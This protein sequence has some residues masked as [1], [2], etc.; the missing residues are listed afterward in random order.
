MQS[1][2]AYGYGIPYTWKKGVFFQ[3][4]VVKS[5]DMMTIIFTVMGVIPVVYESSTVMMKPIILGDVVDCH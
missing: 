4:K 2:T 3:L 5:L 1:I